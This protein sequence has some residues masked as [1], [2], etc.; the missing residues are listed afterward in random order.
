[1]QKDSYS[2]L[3]SGLE[4]SF[5]V[6]YQK[7]NGIFCFIFETIILFLDV[8]LDR[9]YTYFDGSSM[10]KIYNARPPPLIV[11][12]SLLFLWRDLGASST[13][14]YVH[15]IATH[16]FASATSRVRHSA[17]PIEKVFRCSLYT[18]LEDRIYKF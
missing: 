8:Y 13:L 7:S 16:L 9:V 4:L 2:P 10:T 15:R 1:M 11:S 14:G 12:F 3:R 17:L 6:N 18:R 5:L